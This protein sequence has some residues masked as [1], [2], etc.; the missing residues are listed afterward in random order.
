MYYC[1]EQ[2]REER[3]NVDAYKYEFELHKEWFWYD[4]IA[5]WII[6][7]QTHIRGA[8]VLEYMLVNK[9]HIEL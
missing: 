9:C 6:R 8:C 1:E 3:T 4:A 2:W 5:P 7:T